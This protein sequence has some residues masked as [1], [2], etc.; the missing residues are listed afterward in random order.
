MAAI[1]AGAGGLGR[2]PCRGAL[3][4]AITELA[5]RFGSQV[6]LG[7]AIRRQHSNTLTWL[8]SQLPDA[9]VW[10]ANTA[11]VSDVLCIASRHG[12]PVIPFGAGTSLEG[13]VNAPEG[14]ISID[15]SRMDAILAVNA[16]DFDC[17]VEAGVSRKRLNEHLRDSGLYFTVDPGAEDATLGG[18]AATRASGTNAM[19]YGT[20]RD[21]VR[22]VTAVMADGRVIRTGGRAAK[23]AAGYDLT[24]LLIG[25]E[26]T[27]GVITELT[28]KLH[29]VPEA[30]IAAV[31]PF[32]TLEG[33]CETAIEAIQSGVPLAR[34][35]LLDEVQIRAV[36]AYAGLK[37]EEAPTLFI[38]LHASRNSGREQIAAVEALAREHGALAFSWAE[39]EDER[40]QLWRARHNAYWAIR[41]LYAGRAILATDVCVPISQLARCVAETAAD[42]KRSGLMA[43]ILGHVGDGN[44]HATPVFNVADPAEVRALE[45]FLERLTARALAMDG[46]CTGEHGIGQGKIASLVAEFGPAVD[47]MR[48]IKL[49]LDP[50]GILNPGKIF[51]CGT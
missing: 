51:H 30:Q 27:L 3:D 47:V 10:P 41:T 1:K 45:G 32:A 39:T 14:G 9:V 20:M 34:V 2:R 43:P 21:N 16:R 46:T 31:A 37:L 28:V 15:M 48:Q 22:S 25:S 11:Q 7:D 33:A 50:A 4:A 12:V 6:A 40:R 5:A 23:S 18:M 13:H 26:G 35:E 17:T 8:E 44:F 49:A 38:E 42:A 19:R 36:N 29:P 24:R